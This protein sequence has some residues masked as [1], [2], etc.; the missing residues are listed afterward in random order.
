MAIARGFVFCL[1]EGTMKAHARTAENTDEIARPC[2][3]CLRA[4][5]EE[6]MK[7]SARR[8]GAPARGV[9]F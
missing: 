3:A 4:P 6:T 1:R 9:A 8:A 5:C 2:A 7:A